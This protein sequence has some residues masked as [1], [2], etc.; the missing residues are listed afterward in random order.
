MPHL[1]INTCNA[2]TYQNFHKGSYTKERMC[3]VGIYFTVNDYNSRFLI[4]QKQIVQWHDRTLDS[5]GYMCWTYNWFYLECWKPK[6]WN[7]NPE[8]KITLCAT[9]MMAQR[10]WLHTYNYIHKYPGRY[11]D[12]QSMQ[13][14]KNMKSE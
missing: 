10:D 14:G 3:Q 8:R 13:L 1:L 11:N 12:Q 2:S 5:Y 9:I 4:L 7:R 6:C